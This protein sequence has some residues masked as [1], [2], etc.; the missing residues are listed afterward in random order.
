MNVEIPAQFK[1][2]Q[3]AFEAFEQLAKEC[4][5]CELFLSTCGDHTTRDFQN[6]SAHLLLSHYGFG[7]RITYD[8]I[9]EFQ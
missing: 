5:Y 6:Y 2:C 7:S 8:T 9:M 4:G 1:N 3:K